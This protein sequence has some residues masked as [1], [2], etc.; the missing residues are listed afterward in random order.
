VILA[1]HI[2]ALLDTT[3]AD[4]RQQ[5][6]RLARQG[7]VCHQHT[8]H[9][10]PGHYQITSQGLDAIRSPLPVPRAESIRDYRRDTAI[11]YLTITG[12]RGGFGTVLHALPERAMRHHD[13]TQPDPKASPIGEPV[14]GVA[15]GTGIEKAVARHYP[16]LM[17]VTPGGRVAIE[18]QTRL[19]APRRLATQL[20]AYNADPHIQAVLYMVEDDDVFE[21]IINSGK[22]HGFKNPKPMVQR[23]SLDPDHPVTGAG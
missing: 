8:H 13:T 14:Y 9:G 10:Q 11:P 2:R 17:L 20:T 19:P 6:G 7:L 5:L 16:D 4:A 22:Q 23:Y 1:D 12:R 18:L 3:P 21:A 15:L